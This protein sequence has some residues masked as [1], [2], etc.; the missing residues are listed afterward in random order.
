MKNTT[1][2]I[3]EVQAYQPETNDGIL[4][5][6]T[7]AESLFKIL[8]NLSLKCSSFEELND[9]Y[10]FNI[11][12]LDDPNDLLNL[13]KIKH[14]IRL[15][16]FTKNSKQKDRVNKGTNHPRMWAQ[17]ASN[18]RGA[19][20][21]IDRQK[22]LQ[23][24]SLILKDH[25]FTIKKVKYTREKFMI[26]EIPE[27]GSMQ[28]FDGK[29]YLKKHHNL[30]FFNKHADWRDE[31]E[32]RFLGY[33]TPEFLS[34]KESIKFISLGKQFCNE[35]ELMNELIINIA[36]SETLRKFYE[37]RMFLYSTPTI[38]GYKDY[39]AAFYIKHAAD[40]FNEA[41]LFFNK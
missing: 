21:A 23:E 28:H 36:Q 15:L 20:I 24:N 8:E 38:F 12:N 29:N 26:S 4:Y 39:D 30:L 1:L 13:K 18:N 41:L 40:K 37:R 2:P 22:F 17:Y 3:L 5:H 16:C 32:V 14:N 7:T 19:C 31:Q 11:N 35:Q 34:I 6:Y 25:F 27:T 10:E 33:E 9:L